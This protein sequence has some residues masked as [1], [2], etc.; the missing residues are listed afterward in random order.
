MKFVKGNKTDVKAYSVEMTGADRLIEWFNRHPIMGNMCVLFIFIL[1]I[2]IQNWS[3]LVGENLMKYD[4]W[5]AEYP[6]QV[7]MSDAIANH[8]IPMWNPLM[9]YGTPH[10]AMVGTPVWYPFTMLLAC[11]GYT[12][13]VL[14]VSYVMHVVIGG[15]GMFCLAGQEV[16]EK[17]KWSLYSLA[18]SVTAGLLYSTSG[19]FLS[20]AQHIMAIISMAWI[21]YVFYY[22]RCYLEKKKIVFAMMAGLCAGL[23]F[24][25]GYP[26]MFYDLF[27]FLV[28]YVLYF[29]FRKQS[30]FIPYIISS[31]GTYLMIA[32]FTILA[33]AISLFPF[34]KNMGSIT[35]GTGLGQIPQDYSVMTF[36][37][38]ILPKTTQFIQ[39][40]EVSMVNYY[41]GLIV[42]ILIPVI[43]MKI[44]SSKILYFLSIVGAFFL[45]MG[46]NSFLH[47]ILYRFFPMYDSFRFPTLN[48]CFLTVFLLLLF[49][50]TFM[51]VLENGSDLIVIKWSKLLLGALAVIAVACGLMANLIAGTS[52]D[53]IAVRC[54][55]LAESAFISA[56]LTA[57]YWIIFMLMKNCDRN[58]R[59]KKKYAVFLLVTVCV[60][61][62]V[63]AYGEGP[64]TIT[65]YKYTE[66][67]YDQQI[68]D[69]IQ[70]EFEQNKNRNRSVD[71]V[72]QTRSTSSA[73]SQAIVFNKTFD[74]EGYLSFLLKSTSDFK[75]T[76]YR[77]IIEQNPVIYFTNDTV[78]DKDVDYDQWINACNTSPWQIY[79]ENALSMEPAALDTLPLEEVEPRKLDISYQ[80]E[81]AVIEDYLYSRQ[82]KTGRV[83]AFFENYSGG[84]VY[85]SLCFTDVNEE[86][87]SYAGEFQLYESDKGTYADLYFPDVDQ[88]YQR[89]RITANELPVSA[90]LVSV[91]RMAQD[92]YTSVYQFGL[93][94]IAMNVDAPTEGYVTILQ[95]Y[96]DGWS[97]Y[98]DGKKTEI[99]LVNQCF[100]GIHVES[101]AHVLELRFR[102]K[103]FFAGI[104]ISIIYLISVIAAWGRYGYLN[105]VQAGCR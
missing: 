13:V 84:T 63:F 64:I 21:P 81:S 22:V 31:A 73:N 67:S 27:L 4:I 79:V 16:R 12:P 24:L 38:M 34:L 75:S 58:E 32:G 19:I 29:N 54:R 94:D 60:E 95:A 97:A 102:P 66:Y 17:K 8:T 3:L 71:F 52:L 1:F 92:A 45:C 88:V 2:S 61:L 7:L 101:G 70:S 33:S 74:E 105:R 89:L 20:N 80:E 91:E 86:E 87:W 96:H 83:R 18:A 56:G 42:I 99:S 37:S 15:F 46:N 103:E 41:M 90:E 72:G 51:E 30:K 25:G 98:V 50:S 43:I 47:P 82:N 78:S 68:Q 9:Q 26:E 59:C 35:R 100:M 57:A 49:A 10:Y 39:E 44:H 93:N 23:I 40:V 69:N 14:S 104:V 62:F 11:V 36:L 53:N 55:S 77:S 6:L 48:R 28:P 76:Y 85:L 65:R 5:D